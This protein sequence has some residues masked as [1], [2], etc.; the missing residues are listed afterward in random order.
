MAS[1]N[2]AEFIWSTTGTSAGKRRRACKHRFFYSCSSMSLCNASCSCPKISWHAQGCDQFILTYCSSASMLCT[3]VVR[4]KATINL[5][6]VRSWTTN[7]KSSVK[8]PSSF[9]CTTWPECTRMK[10]YVISVSREYTIPFITP[11]NC[12]RVVSFGRLSIRVASS[13]R[14]STVLFV[15]HYAVNAAAI[16]WL[17]DFYY[18]VVAVVLITGLNTVQTHHEQTFESL[19][20]ILPRFRLSFYYVF[21]CRYE[22]R[23]PNEA[24]MFVSEQ[25]IN[26]RS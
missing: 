21:G 19:D 16:Y 6:P 3:E 25:D 20:S 13:G 10:R 17:C 14:L 4:P 15:L 1:S 9:P 5:K 23:A 18:V 22:W 8:Q 2:S 26:A 12:R 11:T 7:W 24:I